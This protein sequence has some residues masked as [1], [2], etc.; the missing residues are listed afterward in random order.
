[1]AY[2]QALVLIQ[3]EYSQSKYQ[4]IKLSVNAYF[5]QI[6]AYLV[7]EVKKLCFFIVYIGYKID[8]SN[9]L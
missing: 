6:K 8:F 9:F 3:I 5:Y 2:L 7:L 1:M 4:K